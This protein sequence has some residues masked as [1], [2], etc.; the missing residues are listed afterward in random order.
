MAIAAKFQTLL[1][2]CQE[3][4]FSHL[5]P[6]MDRM[7]ENADV[8]LLD[9]AEKAESNAA[10]AVFFEAMNEVRKK[11]TSIEQHF[12]TE[13]KSG[14]SSF[15]IQTRPQTNENQDKIPAGQAFP[16]GHRRG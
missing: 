14:F 11:R 13:L 16:G 8:A 7:F 9:F 6:L 3:M 2:S 15:P 12:Y 1:D 4:E 10:Q 5:R